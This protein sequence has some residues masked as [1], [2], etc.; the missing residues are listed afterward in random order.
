MLCNFISPKCQSKV[1]LV[2]GLCKLCQMCF[3][4]NHRL[5]EQHLCEKQDEFNER[6]R[7]KLCKKLNNER[8]S[9]SKIISI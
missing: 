8:V 6:Q 3:C 2:A 5:P 7:E 9:S 4:K 1:F